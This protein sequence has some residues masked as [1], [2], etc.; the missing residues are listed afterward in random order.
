MKN[1]DVAG[2]SLNLLEL[3]FIGAFLIIVMSALVAVWLNSNKKDAYIIEMNKSM[4]EIITK[5]TIVVEDTFIIVKE[6]PKEVRDRMKP[7][8]DSMNKTLDQINSKIK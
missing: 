2:A 7:D 5:L 6:L 8:L 4:V 3:G 1:V